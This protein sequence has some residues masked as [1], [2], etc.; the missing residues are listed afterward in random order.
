MGKSQTSLMNHLKNIESRQ[1]GLLKDSQ[2]IFTTTPE[3]TLDLLFNHSFPGCLEISDSERITWFDN[4]TYARAFGIQIPRFLHM[5][6]LDRA[7]SSFGPMKAAGPDGF[8]PCVLQHFGESAKIRLQRLFAAI[9]EVGY[10][11]LEWRKATVVFIPKPG[12]PDYETVKSFRP[13]SLSSFFLKTLERLVLWEIEST[14]LAEDPIHREQNA[15]RR[16]RGTDTALMSTV[17]FIESAV[18]RSQKCLGIFL[19]IS[20]AFDTIQRVAIRSAM[21]RKGINP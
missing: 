1:L 13:I 15:F 2:G 19:D 17:D 11:P 20:S 12:K 7:I 4:R 16:G 9:V 8:K 3:A 10:T 21:A 18:L 6:K 5:V 14:T